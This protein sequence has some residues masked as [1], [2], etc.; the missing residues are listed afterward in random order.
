MELVLMSDLHLE[1]GDHPYTFDKDDSSRVLVLAGDITVGT[2]HA[3]F[4]ETM[5]ENFSH[6]VMVLGNHEF[7]HNEL[8][9]I[10]NEWQNLDQKISNLHVLDDS[11]ILID[12]VRFVGGTLWSDMNSGDWFTIQK[13]R[14][15]M[16]DY[17][18]IRI[19]DEVQEEC[20]P[21][22]AVPK[23]DENGSRK[24]RPHDTIFLHKKTVQFI[25]NEL[26]KPHDGKTVVVTHH[27]P[28]NECVHSKYRGDTLN[29]AYASDLRHF[30]EHFE[31]DMWL[32]GHTHESIDFNDIYGKKVKCNPKGY[33]S[34]DVNLDFE[35]K[36]IIEI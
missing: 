33:L 36:L 31:F 28:L 10:R 32:H 14:Q 18:T 23:Y 7:Y 8:N 1:F 6:V 13:A 29:G 3:Q 34:H 9:S 12:G 26:S 4:V 22:S 27:L 30:F 5:A 11:T 2:K 21:Y 35:E 20:N 16:N 17:H 25:G 19:I 15:V 24:L